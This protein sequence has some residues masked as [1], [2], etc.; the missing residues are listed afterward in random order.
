MEALNRNPDDEAAFW[1]VLD[2]CSIYKNSGQT[3]LAED[4]LL[5]YIDEFEHIMS[6]EVKD[7]ILQSLYS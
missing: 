5:T 2:I 6:E 3:E 1:I 7:Q 4:I